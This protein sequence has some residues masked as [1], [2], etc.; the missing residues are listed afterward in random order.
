MKLSTML[1]ILSGHV[2]REQ[3]EEKREA[4]DAGITKM[5]ALLPLGPGAA[6]LLLLSPQM[7]LLGAGALALGAGVI[8]V[9]VAKWLRPL[10]GTTDLGFLGKIAALVGV[11]QE[12]LGSVPSETV[13]PDE[14]TL[15]LEDVPGSI[16]RASKEIVSVTPS[17]RAEKVETAKPP[18]VAAGAPE[19]PTPITP[20]STIEKIIPKKGPAPSTSTKLHAGVK[21]IRF[22]SAD[23]E[24]S[25]N[26]L[27]AQGETFRG[28]HGLTPK[29]REALTSAATSQGLPVDWMLGMAQ[30]ESGGNPNAISS[31]G[32]VGLLQ[33]TGGTANQFG[34]KNRFDI[35]ANANAGAALM[36][37]N[38]RSIEAYNASAAKTKRT[39]I[40]V[41][42]TSLYVAHQMGFG[43]LRDI[44]DAIYHDGK[45]SETTR[46]NMGLNLGV[47]SPEAYM[48]ANKA[49]IEGARL[50]AM[51]TTVAESSY[52]GKSAEDST[53]KVAIKP[54]DTSAPTQTA[55][56][57]APTRVSLAKESVSS[58]ANAPAAPGKRPEPVRAP[59]PTAPQA[60]AP[61][62]PSTSHV[63]SASP[64]KG[65]PEL[66]SL[67]GGS[68]VYG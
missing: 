66:F 36:K 1:P 3:E 65:F 7:V 9:E 53:G 49:K 27:Y 12:P 21:M 10:I 29:V 40:P 20:N 55:V 30:F 23:E 41:N 38:L 34:L 35:K 44:H 52:F 31:T 45:L 47:K 63:A 64:G 42:L 54:T 56:A 25:F 22:R 57:P 60:A 33:F 62:A 16:G 58:G 37:A 59:A 43:G 13:R 14:P 28:G 11:T 32:A 50:K 51:S 46:R 6:P 8:A 2:A 19:R 67:P 68:L 17:M 24:S 18:E 5:V 15:T 26:Y 48:A 39:P 61:A 4:P